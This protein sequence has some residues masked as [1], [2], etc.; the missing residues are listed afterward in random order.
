LRGTVLDEADLRGANLQGANLCGACLELQFNGAPFSEAKLDG[1]TILP[2]G[3]K[4]LPDTDLR[5]FTD[6]DHEEFW[7]AAAPESASAPAAGAA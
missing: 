3:S 2:D 4:W 5:R 1:A 6:A 7:N